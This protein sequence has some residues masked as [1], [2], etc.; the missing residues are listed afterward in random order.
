LT[1]AIDISSK[2]LISLSATAWVQW[3]TGDAQAEVQELLGS[4]LQFVSRVNDIL[5]KVHSAPHGDYLVANEIQFN[6]DPKMPLRMRCY[7]AL[8]EERYGLPVYPVVVNIL[9]TTQPIASEHRAEFMGLSVLQ[10]YRVINLWELDAERVLAG[11][12]TTRCCLLCRSCVAETALTSCS[13]RYTLCAASLTWPTL[14]PFL[15]S[16]PATCWTVRRFVR[17]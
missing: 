16:L 6:T 8:I 5:I 13:G 9:P 11:G 3:L 12:M 1:K 10:Q 2:R 15:R 14:R 17:S 7:A 4:E